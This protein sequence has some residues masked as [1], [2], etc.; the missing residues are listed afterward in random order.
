MSSDSRPRTRPSRI[1]GKVIVPS[2]TK[3]PGA[4]GKSSFAGPDSSADAEVSL[5]TAPTGT[6]PGTT[7][8]EAAS[9]DAVQASGSTSDR[10]D[11]GGADTDVET[12]NSAAADSPKSTA[13]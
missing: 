13:N 3:T 11:N 8:D 7:P 9:T 10:G 1:T 6:N 2:G 12:V 4:P 5:E